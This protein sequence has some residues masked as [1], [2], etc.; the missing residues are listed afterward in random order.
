MGPPRLQ[1][2]IITNSVK[3]LRNPYALLDAALAKHGLSFCARLPVV[4][5]A[6]ITGDPQTIQSI[7]K[8]RHLVGGR[9]TRALRPL[10]AWPLP[11]WGPI[12]GARSGFLRRSAV[13][14]A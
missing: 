6:F 2:S 11:R 8:N 13:L 3:W 7:I 5:Q 4:G 9:G 1:G 12:P 14:P 10:L